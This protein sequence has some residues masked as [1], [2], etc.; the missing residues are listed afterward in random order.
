MNTQSTQE[1]Q[2]HQYPE[3]IRVAQ[4]LAALQ[5]KLSTLS[6]STDI[7][8]DN[9]K[10]SS[11]INIDKGFI[12]NSRISVT[13]SNDE[14]T[15]MVYRIKNYPIPSFHSILS[16]ICP[17]LPRIQFLAEN[18]QYL[19][20]TVTKDALQQLRTCERLLTVREHLTNIETCPD[21]N[22]AFEVPPEE[23]KFISVFTFRDS[24]YVTVYQVAKTTDPVTELHSRPSPF[25]FS[26]KSV[27]SIGGQHYRIIHSIVSKQSQQFLAQT[28]R[29]I[30][31]S[32]DEL[33]TLNALKPK[34]S[35][36]SE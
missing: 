5:D 29:L 2:T 16:I 18:P 6:V 34:K 7:F 28:L 32:I 11:T 19:T 24:L 26:P 22:S 14:G 10:L 33:E 20:A 15:E 3:L 30:R 17:W 12:D 8:A 31:D 36:V 13:F 4:N 27:V 35:M 23:D 25:N 21:W 9:H 1:A